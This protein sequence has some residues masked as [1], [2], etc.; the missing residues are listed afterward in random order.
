MIEINDFDV[1]I[2]SYNRKEF[3]IPT[4]NSLMNQTVGTFPITIFDNGSSDG[5]EKEVKKLNQKRILFISAEKNNGVLWNFE[6]AIERSSK[7]YVVLLHD[8]DLI[9][10][11]YFE[12]ALKAINENENV[13]LVCSGMKQ[14]TYPVQN[15]FKSIGCSY[16]V[17][18]ELE[19][20]V[21]LVY[22]GFP[23]NFSSC[24]YRTE[25]VKNRKM[26]MSLYGKIADRPFVFDTVQTGKII[27]FKG[28]FIQYRLHKN[29]D[30]NNSKTGPFPKEVIALHKKYKQII[31]SKRGGLIFK[32]F[33]IIKFYSY[34]HNEH[35]NSFSDQFSLKAYTNLAKNEVGLPYHLM[36]FSWL[37]YILGI[38]FLL[39]IYWPIKRSL[40]QFL[41]S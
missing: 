34:L 1:Y 6:R 12:F 11:K 31:F 35:K 4:L 18:E 15:K 2:L 9:H 20:F 5:T 29:Q 32:L 33:F 37:S 28:E 38:S 7:K 30:S 21:S 36:M 10:P 14:T 27:L 17:Y 23:L 39:R 8:D 22:A 40:K 41:W 13:T 19:K 24:I 3:I 25:N 26:N 16:N